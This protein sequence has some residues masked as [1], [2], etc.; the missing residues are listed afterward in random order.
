MFA[1]FFASCTAAD[2]STTAQAA[3]AAV[4]RVVASSGVAC[5]L[6]ERTPDPLRS[7]VALQL[8]GRPEQALA[9]LLARLKGSGGT[10]AWALSGAP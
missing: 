6:Q 4:R 9:C 2:T 8:V 3:M 1:L 5:A 7:A 10:A